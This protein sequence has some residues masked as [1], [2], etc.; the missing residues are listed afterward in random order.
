MEKNKMT[1]TAYIVSEKRAL[2]IV[3]WTGIV[4]GALKRVAKSAFW[5]GKIERASLFLPLIAQA[6]QTS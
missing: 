5:V 1:T 3:S 2:E 6:E 4:S